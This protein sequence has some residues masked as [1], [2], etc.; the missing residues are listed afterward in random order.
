[1]SYWIS[2]VIALD[3]NPFRYATAPAWDNWSGHGVRLK[4]ETNTTEIEMVPTDQ[5]NRCAMW[6]GLAATMA[7]R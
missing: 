7:Q 2:F 5:L 1:M 6:K 3:P 4:I